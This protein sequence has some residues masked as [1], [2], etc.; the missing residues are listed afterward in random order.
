M[1]LQRRVEYAISELGHVTWVAR[2]ARTPRIRRVL[3]KNARGQSD[4]RYGVAR[5]HP[6]DRLHGIETSLTKEP[7][8][9]DLAAQFD[10]RLY[11]SH[12]TQRRG[13]GF[14]PGHGR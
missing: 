5:L 10:P 14:W 1:K 3:G 2:I 8:D 11:P 9:L 13:A 7:E 4:L 12:F 6:F